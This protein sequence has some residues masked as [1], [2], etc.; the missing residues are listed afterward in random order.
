MYGDTDSLF[1]LLENKSLE[2]AFE[3]GREIAYAVTQQN[4]APVELQLEKVRERERERC[5][6]LVLYLYMT[7]WQAFQAT[8]M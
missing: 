2:A 4:P 1:V 6:Q 7:R 8:R 5:M 3:I